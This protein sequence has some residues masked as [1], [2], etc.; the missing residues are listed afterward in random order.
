ME[1]NRK[2]I[3]KKTTPDFSLILSRLEKNILEEKNMPEVIRILKKP[4]VWEK[5]SSGDMLKRA[6]LLQMAG[7][8]ETALS[9]LAHLNRSSPGLLDA[10]RE[11]IELLQILEK[12]KELAGVLA[13]C[14]SHVGREAI[15]DWTPPFSMGD[16][17][18]ADPLKQAAKPFEKM[19]EREELIRRY[20]TLFAGRQDCFARQWADKKQNRQGYIPVRRPMQ[21]AD[22]E[23]HLSGKK[24]C[25]IYLLQA[26]STVRLAVIDIDI[27]AEYR[28]RK[29]KS[30]QRAQVKREFHYFVTRIKEL[31]KQAGLEPLLEFS[32]GKGYHFWYFFRENTP[33]KTARQALNPIKNAIEKDVSTFSFEVFPKQ[34]KLSGKGFGNLVKLPLGIHRLSGKSSLFIECHSKTQNDQLR[35]LNDVKPADP[36]ELEKGLTEPPDAIVRFHP[37]QKDWIK[38]YPELNQ[39]ENRCPPLA[40]IF[41]AVRNEKSLSVREEKILF[42]TVGFFREA[43]KSLHHLMER[44]PEYNPHMVDYKLSR[45]RGTPLG[46]RR[47]HSLLEYPGDMCRFQNISG[48]PHPLFHLEGWEEEGVK[49]N[50]KIENLA[51]ALDNLKCAVQLVEKYLK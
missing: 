2:E 24:T 50:E 44:I 42:Q 9:V 3:K 43:K 23:D 15:K 51:D 1:E 13:L 29:L 33:A 14:E 26:D 49:K 28:N 48:Y 31:S 47:I 39:L 40:Q 27:N 32:G 30:E 4:D 38:K 36:D 46:C 41:S 16:S 6:K 11:R 22:V 20:L 18:G 37:K 45:I 17:A 12:N 7:E 10:W 5:A 21:P 25:G 35:F 8:A 19:R 34:D